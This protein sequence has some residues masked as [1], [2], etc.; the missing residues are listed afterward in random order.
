MNSR[1][2]ICTCLGIFPNCID[3]I[4]IVPHAIGGPDVGGGTCGDGVLVAAGPLVVVSLDA[5]ECYAGVAGR[6]EVVDAAAA[7]RYVRQELVGSRT[8]RRTAGSGLRLVN[9]I[10]LVVLGNGYVGW[11]I[12][13]QSCQSHLAEHGGL[14]GGGGQVGILL[15][16]N[17]LGHLE[18]AGLEVGDVALVGEV[19]LELCTLADDAG[20]EGLG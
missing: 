2:G 1:R 13:L 19:G 15:G 20:E 12:Q 18:V 5:V 14:D 7:T 11:C 16:C 8:R 9:R 17:G 10:I 3:K 4:P 6:E